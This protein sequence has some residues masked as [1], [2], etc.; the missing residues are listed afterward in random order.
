[1]SL[2]QRVTFGEGFD[3]EGPGSFYPQPP[4]SEL[5][6]DDPRPVRRQRPVEEVEQVEDESDVSAEAQP[7]LARPRP[8]T[9]TTVIE[10]DLEPP[11]WPPKWRPLSYDAF[12]GWRF[13]KPRLRTGAYSIPKKLRVRKSSLSPLPTTGNENEYSRKHTLTKQQ[14]RLPRPLSPAG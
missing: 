5:G 12:T 11:S 9:P 3:Y 6:F 7:L 8:S 4:P 14:S 2:A 13:P 1:M 10:T